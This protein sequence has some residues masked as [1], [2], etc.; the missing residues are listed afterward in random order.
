MFQKNFNNIICYFIV[1]REIV[2]CASDAF[3]DVVS[4]NAHFFCK[5]SYKK[6]AEKVNY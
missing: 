2:K 1:P 3:C 5:S 4:E 6:Q